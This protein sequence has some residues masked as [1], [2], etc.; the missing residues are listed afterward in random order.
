MTI[1]L[2]PEEEAR[3]RQA[4]GQDTRSLGEIL[5]NTA[6]WLLKLEVSHDEA[7]MRSLDKPTAVSSSAMK[8]S[9]GA[10]DLSYNVARVTSAPLRSF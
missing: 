6:V 10:S 4:A 2:T 1:D 5:T 8:K 7:L 3:I 9:K